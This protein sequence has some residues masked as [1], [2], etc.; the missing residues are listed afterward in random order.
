MTIAA[1]IAPPK[2]GWHPVDTPALRSL[3]RRV[4]E[5]TRGHLIRVSKRPI[6]GPLNPSFS[7][8]SSG[9]RCSWGHLGATGRDPRIARPALG[10][11]PAVACLALPTRAREGKRTEPDETGQAVAGAGSTLSGCETRRRRP[12]LAARK[13]PVESHEFSSSSAA[14]SRLPCGL[15]GPRVIHEVSASMGSGLRGVPLWGL[16]I[17]EAARVQR[18]LAPGGADTGTRGCASTTRRRSGRGGERL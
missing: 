12:L 3:Y 5:V 10:A 15:G 8:A 6:G 18:V 14:L 7:L 11:K 16:P 2:L 13:N 9:P 1:P 4:C 17:L